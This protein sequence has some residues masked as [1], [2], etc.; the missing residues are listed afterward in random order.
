MDREVIHVSLTNAQVGGRLVM[1][2]WR[3]V[4]NIASWRRIVP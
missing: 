4:E 1:G 2:L 3:L